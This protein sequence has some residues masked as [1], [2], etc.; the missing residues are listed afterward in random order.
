MSR[1]VVIVDNNA[2]VAG[3]LTANEMSPSHGFST[4]WVLLAARTDLVLVTGDKRLIKDGGMRGRVV[5][6]ADFVDDAM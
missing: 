4:L 6:A 1:S 3:L 2:V 5:S